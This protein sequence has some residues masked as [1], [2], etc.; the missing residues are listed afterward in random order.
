MSTISKERFNEI[1]R[2]EITRE[3][4]ELQELNEWFGG[5]LASGFLD[6]ISRG[7]GII[8][9]AIKQKI[10]ASIL[11]SFGMADGAARH[12]LSQVI[13][14][15][16]LDDMKRIWKGGVEECDFATEKIFAALC[17]F[18]GAE[19]HEKIVSGVSDIP[20]I[21]ALAGWLGGGG[22]I[23]KALFGLSSEAIQIQLSSADTQVGGWMHANV[24]PPLTKKVCEVLKSF[25][26]KSA[27][28]IALGRDGD[29]PS[30]TTVP[31]DAT[32]PA[33]AGSEVFYSM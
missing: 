28:D 17:Q 25:Q 26:S 4:A 9:G 33:A 29:V 3:R 30:N 13:Q 23:N 15:L 16:T 19:I 22:L 20:G 8:G 7:E 27:L 1:L 32:E 10:A 5:D 2:E 6:K 14:Q 24:L 18:L 31:V 11:A 21:G 12:L